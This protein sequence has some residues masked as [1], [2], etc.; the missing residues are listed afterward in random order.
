MQSSDAAP[1]YIPDGPKV[2][3]PSPYR[4]ARTRQGYPTSAEAPAVKAAA[5][6]TGGSR[7]R[8]ADHGWK[9]FVGAVGENFPA[10]ATALSLARWYGTSEKEWENYP[11]HW[12]KKTVDQGCR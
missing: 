9:K 3:P 10:S 2:V 11:N 4:L 6:A 7:V 5:P 1:E 12:E 8:R